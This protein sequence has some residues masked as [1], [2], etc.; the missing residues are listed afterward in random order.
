MYSTLKY[1]FA[2]LA[3][4]SISNGSSAYAASPE[5]GQAE[6]VK[7][8]CWQCHGFSGQGGSAGLR[9]APDPKP[10]ETITAFIRSTNGQMPP[11]SEKILS[12][13]DVEDIYAYLSS[14]PKA[15]D[16]KSIPLLVP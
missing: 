2:A 6:F 8:G 10:I 7:H 15:K 4:I 11:F 3:A 1:C 12:D 16:Y 14:I 13:E 9:L 5:K